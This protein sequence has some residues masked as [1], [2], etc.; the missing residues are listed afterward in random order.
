[1]NRLVLFIGLLLLF[2][3]EIFRVYFIM[4]FP[5]SQ[6]SRTLNYAY[7]L[8]NNIFWLRLIAL[9]IVLYSTIRVFRNNKTWQKISLSLVLV[10]YCGVF[11]YFNYRYE[12]DKIFL[13]PVTKSFGAVDDSMDLSKLVIGVVI[14]GE[15]KAYPIQLIGYHHQVVDTISGK[16]VM[17]TYC[18]VCR[19]GRVYNPVINGKL[20]R[21]RLVGMDQFNAVFEDATTGSWWQQATGQAITG[22]LKG[23]SLQEITS[24]QLPLQVWLRQYPQSMILQP[25][26]TFSTNYFKLEDYDKGLMQS[27]LVKRDAYSWQPKSWIIGIRN[28][29]STKAY[30]WNDLVRKK[31]IQDSVARLPVLLTMEADTTSF[32]VYDRRVNGNTLLFQ[33]AIGDSLLTDENTRSL[34]NMDGLC[35]DGILKGSRLNP[36]QAYNEFWHSWRTFHTN[37]EVYK[38]D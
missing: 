4:P 36:V 18:T 9:G 32:H 13:Q 12:A 26:L 30:D 37:V 11:F 21:F 15:A 24:R 14:N 35:I 29:M 38:T 17:V 6:V 7:W 34:W 25:D 20:E 5:G 28:E 3:P 27:S 33:S 10:A 1:M 8:N 2:L 19:T 22:P 31:I 16:P 23:S